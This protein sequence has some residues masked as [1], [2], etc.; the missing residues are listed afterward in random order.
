MFLFHF[1]YLSVSA[2]IKTVR[3][4]ICISDTGDWCTIHHLTNLRCYCCSVRLRVCLILI[5]MMDNI[6]NAVMDQR[7]W[8]SVCTQSMGWKA[9][10]LSSIRVSF[11]VTC[12]WFFI[13]DLFLPKSGAVAVPWSQREGWN[14]RNGAWLESTSQLYFWCVHACMFMCVC[15]CMRMHVVLFDPNQAAAVS[16]PG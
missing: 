2:K 13:S 12:T 9:A 11:S 3:P 10:G 5:Q 16:G 15:A 8:H 4:I 7:L 14:H 1:Q 6:Y